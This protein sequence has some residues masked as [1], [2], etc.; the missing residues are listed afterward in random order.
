MLIDAC[1]NKWR[2]GCKW[3]N[4]NDIHQTPLV[5]NYVLHFRLFSPK[6][7]QFIN[8]LAFSMIITIKCC[9]KLHHIPSTARVNTNFFPVKMIELGQIRIESISTITLIELI[10]SSF[11]IGHCIE[12]CSQMCSHRLL[13]AIH[14]LS[15]Q[16]DRQIISI[17]LCDIG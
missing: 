7:I 17:V 2:W 15:H 6:C 4:I 3:Q 9:S 1:G 16:N 14:L 5:A 12:I 11:S 10:R 8:K 13:F